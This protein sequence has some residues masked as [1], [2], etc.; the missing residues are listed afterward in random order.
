MNAITVQARSCREL[1]QDYIMFLGAELS[2]DFQ[3]EDL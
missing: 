3:I 2:G 1:S